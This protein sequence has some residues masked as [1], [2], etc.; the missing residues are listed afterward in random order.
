MIHNKNIENTVV[1]SCLMRKKCLLEKARQWWQIQ[2]TV[3]VEASDCFS[4]LSL[5]LLKLL[6]NCEDHFHFYSLPAVHGCIHYWK[7]TPQRN[8]ILKVNCKHFPPF[9]YIFSP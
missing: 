4:G 7:S 2:C 6:H 9:L 1:M 5:Q 8:N 3:P